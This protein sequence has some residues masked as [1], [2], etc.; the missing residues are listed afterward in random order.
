MG[1]RLHDIYLIALLIGGIIGAGCVSTRTIDD[2]IYQPFLKSEPISLE[3][4]SSIKEKSP[5]DEVFA[6]LLQAFALMRTGTIEEK[7]TQKEI[8]DLLASSVSSFED[9]TDTVN[10][11]KAFSLDEGKRF[12]GNATERMISSAMLG[13]FYM[14]Q[15]RCDIALPYLRNA[16]FLDARFQKM[17]FGTDAPFIYALMYRCLKNTSQDQAKLKHVMDAIFRSIRFLNLK[18]ALIMPLMA[19]ANTD[20]RELAVSRRIA[21]LLFE[22]SLYY[23]LLSAQN[24]LTISELL[25]DA[26]KNAE[27]FSASLDTNFEREYKARIIPS[28]DE[29]AKLYGQTSK[30]EKKQ[31]VELQ[32]ARLS[33]E[34]KEIADSLKKI[35]THVP[36]YKKQLEEYM[37]KTHKENKE[38]L[39][40]L[41]APK[42]VLNFSGRGPELKREGDYAEISHIIPSIDANQATAIRKRDIKTNVAC[43]FHRSSH[44]GFALVLCD[45]VSNQDPESAIKSVPSLELMS[46]SHKATTIQGRSFDQILKGRA[47]FRQATEGVATISKLS[48]LFLFHL[49]ARMMDE[50]Q[51][52]GGQEDCVA[53][54]MAVW[55]VAALTGV[56][57]GA[58]WLIGKTVNPA[59]DSRFIHLMYES[60]W[61][62]I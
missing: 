28:I 48:A 41:D 1:K 43:G 38:I 45:N 19:M 36:P 12:L 39:A 24:N 30:N 15:N 59:Q 60:Y 7:S 62:G 18:E 37:E 31:L 58:I 25:D 13:V 54:A 23:T 21:Y 2:P 29:L 51:A 52:Q 17:P 57:S 47:Q 55:G 61:L 27:I 42:L 35:I 49:G 46:M 8:M 53:R 11:S 14:A 32:I 10:V 44:E 56:F 3:A 50:C 26:Q 6:E 4:L 34:T 22:V 40:A 33:F 16:E 9:M 5:K 20:M